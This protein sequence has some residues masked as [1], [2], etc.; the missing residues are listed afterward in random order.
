MA[1]LRIVC[2][3]GRWFVYVDGVRCGSFKSRGEAEA[4]IEKY[5]D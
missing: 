4:W 5:V 3:D 2:E 1:E